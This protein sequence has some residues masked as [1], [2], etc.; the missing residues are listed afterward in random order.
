[1]A[2]SSQNTLDDSFDDTFDEL[3]DQHFDQAFENF[4]I[5]ADQEERRKKKKNELISKEIVK[6][7]IFVYG[8][9]ISVTLQRILIIL[10]DDVLE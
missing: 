8:M 5:H 9:I 7:G 2:S 10:S 6:K 4:A 1:M 3:F